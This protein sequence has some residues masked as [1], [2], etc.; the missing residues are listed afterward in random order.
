VA[1]PI[2]LADLEWRIAMLPPISRGAHLGGPPLHAERLIALWKVDDEDDVPLADAFRLLDVK[3]VAGAIMR[4]AIYM[5]ENTI[6]DDH[7]YWAFP[8][9]E[10]MMPEL[11]EMAWRAALDGTLQIDAVKAPKGK[12]R[13]TVTSAELRRL[14]PDWPG[15]GLVFHLPHGDRDAFVDARVRRAPA[16]W[17]APVKKPWS[18]KKPSEA[19]LRNAMLAIAK[20]YP[21]GAKPARE[22]IWQ[23][24]KGELGDGVTRQQARDALNKYA[25]QLRG[26]RGRRSKS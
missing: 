8:S 6:T 24:L 3:A 4:T 7:R 13:I 23:R 12:R 20:T 26:E 11:Q 21:T 1:E 17:V 18:A 19:P 15:S 2:V 5:C 14:H 22:E 16:A 10:A 9:L 25:P